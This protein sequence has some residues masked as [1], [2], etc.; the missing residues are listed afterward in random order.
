MFYPLSDSA[1]TVKLGQH[2]DLTTHMRVKQL[3]EELT[4]HPMHGVV[5]LVP[6]YT[7]LTVYY[8]P[9]QLTTYAQSPYEYV[10]A[11]LRG[12]L[13]ALGLINASADVEQVYEND[14][15]YDD[16]DQYD[17]D[18]QYDGQVIDIPVCYDADYAPDLAFVAAHNGLGEDE[19]CH[20]HSN[21][22]YVVS[23][24]GFMPGFPY[25]GG[26]SPRIAAPRKATPTTIVPG[27]VG[28]AGKQ[29]GI[30]PVQSPGGWQI[31]GRTPLKLFDPMRD[32]PCLLKFGDRIRFYPISKQTFENWEEGVT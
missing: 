30:Y 4:D 23:M 6:S 31:I 13:N 17:G 8:D 28:I 25:L 22:Q 26:M 15:K 2:I 29:T 32:E 27:S 18:D 5:E 19:V 9:L 7:T 21:A 3:F 24:L 12:R 1:V 11:M 16:H 10:C 20:I 14:D